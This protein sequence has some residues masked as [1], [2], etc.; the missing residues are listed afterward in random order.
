MRVAGCKK[1]AGTPRS[2]RPTRTFADRPL[3]QLKNLAASKVP[4]LAQSEN[5][6]GTHS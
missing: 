1:G 5:Q 2:E 3:T 4:G 6:A